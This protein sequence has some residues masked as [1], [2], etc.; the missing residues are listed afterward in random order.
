MRKKF[1]VL[2]VAVILLLC[3]SVLALAPKPELE[4][5]PED[6]AGYAI[7]VELSDIDHILVSTEVYYL[8]DWDEALWTTV[9]DPDRI[10]GVFEVISRQ[11]VEAA[12]ASMGVPEGG[13][14]RFVTYVLKDGSEVEIRFVDDQQFWLGT[15]TLYLFKEP[16]QLYDE[17]DEILKDYVYWPPEEEADELM[18]VDILRIFYYEGVRYR[19]YGKIEMELPDG[20]QSIGRTI[21]DESRKEDDLYA[22]FEGEVFQGEDGSFCVKEDGERT[23]VYFNRDPAQDVVEYT[24]NEHLVF[25]IS[26][27]TYLEI[28]SS[29]S[30][31]DV[32]VT[33]MLTIEKIVNH[34]AGMEFSLVE[35]QEEAPGG[36]YNLIFYNNMGIEIVSI[37]VSDMDGRQIIYEGVHYVAENESAIDVDYIAGLVEEEA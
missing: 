9:T 18:T 13:G 35:N 21:T 19:P 4:L 25:D 37:A 27:F 23:Y 22:N 8:D 26:G 31:R 17:I 10:K 16:F 3:A 36:S 29:L 14:P 6:T 20:Y 33:D 30:E 12:E 11:K 7:G 15:E 5:Q 32:I 2:I 34:I 1:I 24:W 28:F